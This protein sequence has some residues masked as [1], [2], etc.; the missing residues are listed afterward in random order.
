M[1]GRLNISS[2]TKEDAWHL[3]CEGRYEAFSRA[4]TVPARLK[5]KEIKANM[6][7]GVLKME[8]PKDAKKS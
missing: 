1:T 3:I 5:E 7:H 6:E 4:F 2:S 8:F